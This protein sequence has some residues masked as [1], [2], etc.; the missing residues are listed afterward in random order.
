MMHTANLLR[1]GIWL[2]LIGMGLGMAAAACGDA[3]KQEGDTVAE[4]SLKLVSSAFAHEEVIP[5]RHTCDGEDLSPPLSWTGAPTE[6]KAFALICD[7]PDAPMGTWDHWLLFNI[8][9]EK[10]SLPEGVP[11]D[12]EQADGSLGGLNSWQRNGYGGPC[13]P[14]GKPH[15]YFFR[16]YA[17]STP[18]ELGAEAT[19]S[20]LLQAMEGTILASGTLMGLYGR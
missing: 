3:G 16:I 12:A 11:A 14:P 8:P 13:P 19:K 7:D 18:V 1:P 17:L 5:V 10:T 15:R 6:T 9:A 20:D 4:E 2:A